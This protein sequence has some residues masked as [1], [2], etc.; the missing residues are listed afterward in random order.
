[1]AV[2]DGITVVEASRLSDGDLL[3]TFSDNTT[4]LFHANFLYEVR[5]HDSNVAIVDPFRQ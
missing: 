4:V 1:M 3:I 5:E 2:A